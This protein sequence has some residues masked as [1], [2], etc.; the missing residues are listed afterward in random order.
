M[1]RGR[2]RENPEKSVFHVATPKKGLKTHYC[3]AKK[4]YLEGVEE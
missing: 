2:D 3:H 1:H 4:A